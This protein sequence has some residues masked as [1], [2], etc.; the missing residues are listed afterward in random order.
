MGV[1]VEGV[2]SFRPRVPAKTKDEELAIA[3]DVSILAKI[4]G[5]AR[6][7]RELAEHTGKPMHPEARKI[8]LA[9]DDKINPPPHLRLPGPRNE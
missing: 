8:A 4:E 5:W 3:A 6:A 1:V 2:F 9:I 7:R